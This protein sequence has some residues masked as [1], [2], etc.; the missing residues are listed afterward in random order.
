MLP[1]LIHIDRGRA[2]AM[3]FSS[4]KISMSESRRVLMMERSGPSLEVG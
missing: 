3:A 2:A 4:G 1:S